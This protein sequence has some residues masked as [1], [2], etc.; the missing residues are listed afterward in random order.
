[1]G[2]FSKLG[3]RQKILIIP[4][5]GAISF[6]IYVALST[7]TAIDNKELLEKAR[8]KHFPAL[9]LADKSLVEFERIKETL[10]AAVTTGDED[11]LKL[12]GTRAKQL[13]RY[14]S[15]IKSIDPEYRND[16]NMIESGFNEYFADAFDIS[17]SMMRGTVD[18]ETLGDRTVKFNNTFDQALE[19]LNKFRNDL[20]T[21]FKESIEVAN[22]QA[23][24]IVTVGFIV[25]GI[26]IVLLFGVSIPISSSIRKNLS[27]VILSL[28]GIAQENGDLTVRLKTDSQDEIGDL[29]FWFNSFVEKLQK[30]I[31]QVVETVS[32]VASLVHSLSD[33]S[34]EAKVENA[35]QRDS[36]NQ[37]KQAVDDMNVS[38]TAVANNAAD[39]ASAAHTANS[40]TEKG[41][42][43]VERTVESINE[44]AKNINEASDVIGKLEADSNSVSMVLDVIKG[45]AEQT[46]LLA[47]NAAIEAARAGEQGR[48]FAVVAD[49]VRSLA[50]RT[51]ES[52]EEINKIIEKLQNAARSAVGVMGASTQQAQESVSSAGEA[53]NSLQTIS[54]TIQKINSMNMEIAHSTDEQ[55]KVASIIVERMTDINNRTETASERA[56]RLNHASEQLEQ[57]ATQLQTVAAQ[58]KV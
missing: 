32:P 4:S 7:N 8:D 36:A 24:R 30:V 28:K 42:Q 2:F 58:F 51:Q 38:V 33:L 17:D 48:G 41:R 11:T 14:F 18:F 22:L 54:E 3:I 26:T 44:L 19:R 50:S 10:S 31:K 27:S 37:T 45:I 49:E 29:V 5:L 6:F 43:V 34:E 39:A 20:D 9:Q 53:G 46:N 56:N 40:E 35:T 13:N 15:D 12:A 52:T 25:G 47:L 57:M 1:M 21:T 23:E 16:I 55:Q